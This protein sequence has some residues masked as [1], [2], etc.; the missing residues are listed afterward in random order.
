LNR[1][2][3][4]IEKSKL[5]MKVKRKK[6]RYKMSKGHFSKWLI[7]LILADRIGVI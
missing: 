3:R 4:E 2:E 5:M 7:V 1:S 6:I